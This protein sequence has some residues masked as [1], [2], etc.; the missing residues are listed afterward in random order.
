MKTQYSNFKKKEKYIKALEWEYLQD[1]PEFTQKQINRPIDVIVDA[2][3][4]DVNQ[5]SEES[6][7]MFVINDYKRILRDKDET[8]E[9]G[10]SQCKLAALSYIIKAEEPIR[11]YITK[12]AQVPFPE[13]H[14]EKYLEFISNMTQGVIKDMCATIEAKIP[15]TAKIEYQRLIGND[16]RKASPEEHSQ[17]F[18]QRFAGNKRSP[19][20]IKSST[21]SSS[22]FIDKISKRVRSNDEVKSNNKKSVTTK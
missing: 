4:F 17:S 21:P 7:K 1:Y 16:P 11:Y 2:I 10:L 9:T 6:L 19:E 14:K 12:A 5:Y 20:E 18:V 13:E 8:D 15:N 3:D 22:S